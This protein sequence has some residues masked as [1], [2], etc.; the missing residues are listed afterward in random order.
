MS[1][2]ILLV[3]LLLFKHVVLFRMLSLQRS[4]A[5]EEQCTN[6]G[7]NVME[8]VTAWQMTAFALRSIAAVLRCEK[9]PLFGAFN[10]RQV[11]NACTDNF[12]RRVFCVLIRRF[13]CNF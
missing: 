12:S 8:T 6:L 11:L 5:L 10:T 4:D 1:F 3:F 13:I 2:V 7:K 9:K